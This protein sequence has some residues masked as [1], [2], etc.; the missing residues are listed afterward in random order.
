MKA[1]LHTGPALA[2]LAMSTA[3]IS[4]YAP[5]RYQPVHENAEGWVVARPDDVAAALSSA[6]L[7]VG[8]AGEPSGAARRL[9]AQMAR[10]TDGAAHQRRRGRVQP[11]LPGAPRLERD[12]WSMTSAELAGRRGRWDAMELAR[13]V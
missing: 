6:A 12:A 8:T 9:Q 7:T 13:R 10:F 5:L 3:D 2:R 4:R 11:L 1:R